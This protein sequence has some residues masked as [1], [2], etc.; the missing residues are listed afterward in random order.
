[1]NETV[2]SQNDTTN[3]TRSES[4]NGKC[5][6]TG[7]YKIV[8][9]SN[10]HYYVGSSKDI[11]FRWRRHRRALASGRHHSRR[12]QRAWNKYGEQRFDFQIIE[13][14]SAADLLDVEQR[15]L[16][17]A[18]TEPKITYNVSFL[19][20]GGCT[21]PA[22][23]DKIKRYWTDSRRKKRANDMTGPKNPFFGK[24]HRKSAREAVGRTHRGKH[25]SVEHKKKIVQYGTDNGATDP[26]LYSFTNVKTGETF[27]GLRIDFMR[28]FSIGR[29]VIDH[30]VQ[31]PSA[32]SKSGWTMSKVKPSLPSE[33]RH[34]PVTS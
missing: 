19:A 20:G 10:G 7:I 9:R 34:R 23:I 26:M 11:M 8:N 31:K 2:Q 6:V 25:L 29:S 1:M 32:V 4:S 33:R 22:I 16:D 18:K 3:E 24:K 30:F 12:L 13:R 27:I 17:I 14:L 28:K 21:D 15:Y 5:V